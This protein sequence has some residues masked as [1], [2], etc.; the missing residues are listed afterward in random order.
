MR[1]ARSKGHVRLANVSKACYIFYSIFNI[2][3]I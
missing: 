1:E 2:E 3:I